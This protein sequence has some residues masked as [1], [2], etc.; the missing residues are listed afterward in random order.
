MASSIKFPISLHLT[1][2]SLPVVLIIV[3]INSLIM[4]TTPNVLF[5]GKVRRLKIF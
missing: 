5:Q 1:T 4:N 2:H 3:L